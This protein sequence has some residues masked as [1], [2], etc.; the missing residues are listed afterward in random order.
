MQ[1]LANSRGHSLGVRSLVLGMVCC[2]AA[3]VAGWLPFPIGRLAFGWLGGGALL[4]VWLL[5]PRRDGLWLCLVTVTANLVGDLSFGVP[6]VTSLLVSTAACLQAGAIVWALDRLCGTAFSVRRVRYL[7]VLVALGAAMATIAAVPIAVG[8]RNAHPDTDLFFLWWTAWMTEVQGALVVTPVVLA[9][10][11]LP[12]WPRGPA[13]TVETAA[14][15]VSVPLVLA[16]LF[17]LAPT[18]EAV[19]HYLPVMLCFPLLLWALLRFS[20]RGAMTL[21]LVLTVV[22]VVVALETSVAMPIAVPDDGL[23]RRLLLVLFFA[24]LRVLF[25]WLFAAA[26][27]EREEAASELRRLH[28]DQEALV[29]ARTA[30]LREV[31]E[32]LGE[33][34]ERFRTFMNHA[35]VIAFIKDAEGRYVY[36]NQTWARQ[37]GTEDETTLYGKTDFDL[38]PAETAQQFR[39]SD[40]LHFKSGA[41]V[42]REEHGPGPEAERRWWTVLK[43]P[44]PNAGG[45]P[46]LGG[47]A[48]D[49]TEARR[50]AERLSDSEARNRA[51]LRAVPDMLF[52]HDADGVYLDCHAPNPAILFLPREQLLGHRFH[53][54]MP[55]DAAGPLE[56]SH[57]EALRTGDI[58]T[59]E[60]H[61][62]FANGPRHYESRAV[63]CDDG[64]VLCVV[65]DITERKQAEE[66]RRQFEAKLLQTQKLESLG[67]LAGGIAHDFNNLLTSVLGY[68]DLA[69]LDLPETG[70][71]A[72]CLNQIKI[73]ARRAAELTR[74]MLAYSGKGR[75]VVQPLQLGEL[76]RE[77]TELLQVSIPRR[78]ELRIHFAEPQ[79]IVEADATQLR[80]VAMNLILNAG[81]ALGDRPGTINV[82][83]GVRDCDRAYLAG[84][85]LDDDLPPGRYAYLEVA[86][87]GCGMTPEVLARI[88]DPFFTTKFTGRGL[89]LAAVLGI[90]R[91]HRGALRVESAVGHGTTFTVLFPATDLEVMATD[92][93]ANDDAWRGGGT[94]LVIDDE[95]AVRGLARAML[96]SLGFEVLTAD[97]GDA[98]VRVFSDHADRINAVLVDVAMPQQ[99]GLQTVQALRAVRL[100]ARVIVVSG[101]APDDEKEFAALGLAGFLQKPYHRQELLAVLRAALRESNGSAPTD[102]LS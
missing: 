10:S 64:K 48:L 91:G 51:L 75:F 49:I 4:G 21:S 5:G 19:L 40:Q 80:Q 24:N 42:Q 98:G 61:L 30:E 93:A 25:T 9:W 66:Q 28:H 81:E 55:A 14:F 68:A 59:A 101:S 17:A 6:L 56:H 37:F 27:S 84:S 102:T 72:E 85:H 74:Q 23:T 95:E 67:V 36:G 90:V 20:F 15:L 86:D 18:S 35:P 70:D 13:R 50:Q 57:R 63:R 33:S 29:A 8:L 78:C 34:E 73:A 38:W 3:C 65:R 54:L 47:I 79:P 39:E 1:L 11:T 44:I 96:Q 94:V 12:A 82:S 88:F 32:R 87:D 52:L 43:V 99:D 26:L 16:L 46:L 92:T 77:M 69:L 76:V 31:N 41:V 100:N 83:A 60:Y 2:A 97:G 53:D 22:S 7:L 89:G 62:P 58:Q 45:R 71:A